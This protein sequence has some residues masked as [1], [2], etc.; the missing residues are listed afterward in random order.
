MEASKGGYTEDEGTAALKTEV[1][2]DRYA[3][4][5]KLL[6]DKGADVNKKTDEGITA[7][8]AASY[9]GNVEVVKLLLAKGADIN[10]KN[11]KGET[12]LMI[13]KDK[14]KDVMNSKSKAA[15]KMAKEQGK[16]EIVVI[17]EKAGAKE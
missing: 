17:L 8:M 6:L 5:V 2:R 4:V 16:A 7:L 3:E 15:L 11:S 13:A 10:V 14:G 1:L 12:A 9:G